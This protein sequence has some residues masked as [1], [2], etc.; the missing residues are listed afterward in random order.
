MALSP[1]LK[2]A[3]CAEMPPLGKA[4]CAQMLFAS[5]S[6]SAATSFNGVYVYVLCVCTQVLNMARLERRMQGFC[7]YKRQYTTT[8]LCSTSIVWA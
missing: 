6:C 7:G 3:E 5:S 2:E 4:A 8:T 1:P